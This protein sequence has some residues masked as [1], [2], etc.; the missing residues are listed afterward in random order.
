MRPF[1][2]GDEFKG[3]QIGRIAKVEWVDPQ[4]HFRAVISDVKGGFDD[5]TVFA[6]QFLNY[7]TLTK[8]GPIASRSGG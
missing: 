8:E 5:E 4:D 2:V 6:A 1:R 7:W 3:K